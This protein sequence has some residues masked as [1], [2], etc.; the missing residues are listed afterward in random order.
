MK[1]LYDAW[2]VRTP[3]SEEVTYRQ[4]RDAIMQH[5]KTMGIHLVHRRSKGPRHQTPRYHFWELDNY[6]DAFAVFLAFGDSIKPQQYL[7]LTT[8]E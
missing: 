1:T 6:T 8:G 3:F 5:A 2:E 7:K 4:A